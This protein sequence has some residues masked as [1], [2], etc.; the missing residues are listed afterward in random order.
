M[1]FQSCVLAASKWVVRVLGMKWAKIKLDYENSNGQ[2]HT[3]SWNKTN[4][5][6]LWTEVETF[7]HPW[8][9]DPSTHKYVN[10]FHIP[11]DTHYLIIGKFR[12][13]LLKAMSTREAGW[14]WG[15][16]GILVIVMMLL[17]HLN[18]ASEWLSSRS[19]LVKSEDRIWI[20]F[21]WYQVS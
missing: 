5:F 15:C 7:Q 6:L 18:R 12:E 16:W 2:W 21:F 17:S 1:I 4:N 10:F 19:Q 11:Q 3:F 9:H 20:Q 13:P 14:G 8:I